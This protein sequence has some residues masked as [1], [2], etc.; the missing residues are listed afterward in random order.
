MA[1]ILFGDYMKRLKYIE[2]NEAI[3]DIKDAAQID[4][5]IGEIIANKQLHIKP[6]NI[7]RG[8]NICPH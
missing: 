3:L 7:F 1:I 8:I 2:Y 4:T 5:L 6:C